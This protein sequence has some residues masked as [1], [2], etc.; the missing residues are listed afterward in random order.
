MTAPAVAPSS[1]CASFIGARVMRATLLDRCGRPFWGPKSA[2]VSKGFVSVEIA[3]EVE[4]GEDYKVRNAAGELCV[5]DKGEDSVTWYTVTVEFCQVDPE[6][7]TLLNR[8]WRPVTNASRQTV[9]GWRQG[10]RFSNVLGYALELWPKITGAGAGQACLA[11]TVPGAEIDPTIDP[12]GYFLLPW[13]ISMAPD[14]A[15][16]ENSPVSFK[17]KG[18]TRA[19]S[20]WGHGPYNVTRDA[21]GGPAPLLDAID[22]GF[23][24]PAWELVSTGDP[25]HQHAEIV[26]V[27][28]PLPTCGA[29]GLWNPD[30]TAP[31]A[32][33]VVDGVDPSTVDFTV[34]NFALVGNAGTVHWGDGASTAMTS[35]SAGA[36]SHDYTGDSVGEQQTI[37]FYAANG[38]APVTAT[39]TP[40]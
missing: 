38:A 16:F 18:R 11:E 17:L 28:P 33:A 4:D 40:A 39:F 37:T 5:N 1:Q 10:E 12:C 2:V 35:G 32:T 14:S 36:V 8:T 25:D 6:M 23:D 7:F 30:A 27:A 21:D 29:I 3:P 31:L 13:V 24:V 26:T 34:T 22:P 20:L 9:T 19:G 15:T